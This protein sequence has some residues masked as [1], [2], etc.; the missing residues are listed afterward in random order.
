[1]ELD[2]MKKMWLQYDNL[3][4]QNK[5]LNEQLINTMLKEKSANAVSRILRFEYLSAATCILLLVIYSCMYYTAFYSTG[6]AVCY[7]LSVVW[8]VA[9]LVLFYKKYHMLS[10]L[11][12]NSGTV[13]Q[14][15]ETL[16]RFRLLVIKERVWSL[17]LSPAIIFTVLVV[18]ARWVKHVDIFEYID[19]YLPRIIIG[20][21]VTILL[22]A[23]TYRDL[24]F[25]NIR[26]IKTNLDE[27]AKF[28]AA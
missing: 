2:D 25:K 13:S 22:L 16:E 24:Y 7:T 23:F 4:Q 15:A 21:I 1:M 28:K 8:L 14:T 12:Y 27:I 17:L 9:S 11:N 5:L 20:S 10:S 26:E 18:I 3:L 6:M 19:V